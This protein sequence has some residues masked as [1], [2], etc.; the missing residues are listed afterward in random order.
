MKEDNV[1]LPENLTMA[2]IKVYH[3]NWILLI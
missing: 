2:Q 3:L 1:P